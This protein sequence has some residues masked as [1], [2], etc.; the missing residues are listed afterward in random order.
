MVNNI[1]L[2]NEAGHGTW[3]SGFFTNCCGNSGVTYVWNHNTVMADAI[4]GSS[5][6]T[7]DGHPGVGYTSNNGQ[8]VSFANNIMWNPTASNMSYKLFN[9]GG[10]YP[11][12][13]ACPPAACNYNDGWNMLTDGG[14][15]TGGANGYADVFS[16]GTPG[17]N[18][19]AINPQFVDSTRNVATFD[20][21]YLGNTAAA[22]DGGSTYSVGAMVASSDASI[23]SNTAIGF[24]SGGA[25]INYRY[26]NGTWNGTACGG[27]N[28]KPGIMTGAYALSRACWELATLYRLR[29]GV[30][31]QTLCDDQIIG[32]H[33]VDIITVLIQW[34]RAGFSPTNEA[35]VLA[36][37]DGQDIGAV[38]VT[39]AAPTFQNS[40]TAARKV[41]IRGGVIR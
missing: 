3:W 5:G 11:N 31:A 13:N 6:A 37:S 14:G 23:Y 9:A 41:I 34:I 36:G 40:N 20:T 21:A 17:I 39:F 10:S 2:P 35:L 1:V 12:I 25:V 28:P 29:Q 15:F 33:E 30:A 22:W 16:G 38:P 26:T 4:Y 27:A 24:P 8:I 32:A 19:L 18:D 7:V